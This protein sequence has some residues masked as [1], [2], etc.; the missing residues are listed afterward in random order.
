MNRKKYLIRRLLVF[1]MYKYRIPKK[2]N[3]FVNDQNEFDFNS[4]DP[5]LLRR[6]WE[7]L[8][9]A[10]ILIQCDGEYSQL[11]PNILVRLNDGESLVDNE[12]L[13]GIAAIGYKKEVE[14]LNMLVRR[15]L[16]NPNDSKL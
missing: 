1:A 5:A 2:L 6:E 4:F 15:E 11:S 8:H 16:Y 14:Y 3:D 10:E 7:Y 9:D 12:F 13:Y